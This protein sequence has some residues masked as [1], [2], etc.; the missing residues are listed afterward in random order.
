MEAKSG[1]PTA[2]QVLHVSDLGGGNFL[3]PFNS[4]GGMEVKSSALE[5]GSCFPLVVFLPLHL[6][7]NSSG[8]MGSPWRRSFSSPRR[9]SNSGIGYHASQIRS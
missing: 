9:C 8:G 6:Y 3:S 4:S 5:A 1:L 7:M 2:A